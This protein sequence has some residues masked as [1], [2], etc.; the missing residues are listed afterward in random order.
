MVREFSIYRIIHTSPTQPT[1]EYISS[2][3]HALPVIEAALY[4][5]YL[6][7]IDL[8][9]DWQ[10]YRLSAVFQL[11]FAFACHPIR[12]LSTGSG[13]NPTGHYEAGL[14]PTTAATEAFQEGFRSM[15]PCLS[16]A[17]VGFREGYSALLSSHSITYVLSYP[18]AS[19]TNV[20]DVFLLKINHML[21][22][23]F[24]WALSLLLI[25][26]F[27]LGCLATLNKLCFS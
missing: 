12:Q 6:W 22:V 25:L 18:Q 8:H 10:L 16:H 24:Y 15:I 20:L 14:I 2:H 13:T 3:N 5:P 7:S 23:I 19:K 21:R 26:R 17:S 27:G 1:S 11:H 4:L 9:C